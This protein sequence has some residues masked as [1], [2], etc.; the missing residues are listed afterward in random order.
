MSAM[1]GGSAQTTDVV[2]AKIVCDTCRQVHD[3]Y[4]A[5]HDAYGLV[6]CVTP[7]GDVR[8]HTHEPALARESEE[9]VLAV[10]DHTWPY[11]MHNT[12]NYQAVIEESI[13][14]SPNGD[15]Y[16][17]WGAAPCPHCGTLL[18]GDLVPGTKPVVV[19]VPVVM[20]ER[21]LW[22]RLSF[23]EKR[24]RV[25]AALNRLWATYGYAPLPEE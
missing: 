20:V 9:L 7:R 5:T 2:L 11:C 3:R 15:K 21:I 12:S 16:Y 17:L 13:D 22:N 19:S 8:F 24:A 14:P 25:R 10:A 23:A 4:S 18:G 6:P 1:H